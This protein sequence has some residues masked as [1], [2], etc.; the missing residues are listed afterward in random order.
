MA[1]PMTAGA[2]VMLQAPF[3]CPAPEGCKVLDIETK[4][5]NGGPH[6]DPSCQL[7]SGPKRSDIVPYHVFQREWVLESTRAF[8]KMFPLN[9]RDDW[10][11]DFEK[12][13]G[14]GSEEVLIV[15]CEDEDAAGGMWIVCVTVAAKTELF[16]IVK[17]KEAEEIAKKKAIEDEIAAKAAAEE[18][19]KNVEYEDKPLIP[20]PWVSETTGGTVDEISQLKVKPTRAMLSLSIE[21]KYGDLMRRRTDPSTRAKFSNKP[22]A[23]YLECRQQKD[24]AFPLDGLI[25]STL[26]IGFQATP[27][28]KEAAAQT[29][30]NRPLNKAS[31]SAAIEKS[32]EEQRTAITNPKLL[33]FL[34]SAE[35]EMRAAL[36]QN[37]TLDLFT[38]DFRD[39]GEDEDTL[40]KQTQTIR[41]LQTFADNQYSKHK[42]AAAVDWH[43]RKRDMVAVAVVASSQPTPPGGAFLS[44]FDQ[45]AAASG[46]VS[47]SHLLLWS[48]L[49]PLRPQLMLETPHDAY[50]FR[51]NPTHPHLIA[52]GCVSGQV[53]V[54]DVTEAEAA[55]EKK[56]QQQLK[57][58]DQDD[59]D[60]LDERNASIAP[61]Q[62]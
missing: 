28:T 62:Y 40:G 46:I 27:T 18:A 3:S 38:D 47:V 39:V 43:P 7:K 56:K 45:R 17:E 26:D 61:V 16:S 48:F 6:N 20:K 5:C 22:E 37:E 54:W 21:M 52:A 11:T 51:F 35:T 55:L 4:W 31:Q 44:P 30:W 32:K 50:C 33:A 41:T 8:G 49:D 1:L 23:G 53:C 42:S 25:Q 36:Q 10:G 60:D 15:A 14:E 9:F 24:P 58:H 12:Y 29:T 59:E 2:G 19:L 57:H 13:V 34:H